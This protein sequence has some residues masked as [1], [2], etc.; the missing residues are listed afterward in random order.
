[1]TATP[2]TP[3]PPHIADAKIVATVNALVDAVN[4][5]NDVSTPAV[6]VD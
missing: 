3:L 1:M 6:P 5:L 4:S 2:I